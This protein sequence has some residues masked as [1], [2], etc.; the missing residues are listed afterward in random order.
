VSQK[1]NAGFE[2]VA[3]LFFFVGCAG[4]DSFV[5]CYHWGFVLK[6]G[7]VVLSHCLCC[8]IAMERYSKEQRIL[9][10]KTHYQNGEHYA[11]TGCVE[12][13]ATHLDLA[14]WTPCDFSLWGYTK[15][16]VYQNKVRN[17]LELKQEI[18]RILNELDGAMCDR[19][20]VNF[21]ERIIA[22]RASRG[23]I[24]PMLFFTVKPQF[25]LKRMIYL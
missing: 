7:F 4:F 14:T 18:S 2:K 6:R 25:I 20:M 19:V 15:S 8:C 3:V 22:C 23:V 9:I 12:T 16:R 1:K 13:K 21:M 10:V 17:V 5:I 11:V 24:C